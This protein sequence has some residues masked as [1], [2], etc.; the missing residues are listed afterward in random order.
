MCWALPAS[1]EAGSVALS[2]LSPMRRF[3]FRCQSC[4]TIFPRVLG[5]CPSCGNRNGVGLSVLLVKVLAVV[6]FAVALGLAVYTMA[7]AMGGP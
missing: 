1:V 3:E 4:A 7:G 5:H 6:C 2:A